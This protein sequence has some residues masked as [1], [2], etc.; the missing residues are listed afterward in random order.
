M[1]QVGYNFSYVFISPKAY[2][3]QL[4]IYTHVYRNISKPYILAQSILYNL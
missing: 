2:M 3:S 1:C 4:D